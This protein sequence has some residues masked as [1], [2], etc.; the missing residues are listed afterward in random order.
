VREGHSLFSRYLSEQ[1]RP[2]VIHAHNG[3]RAG[4]LARSIAREYGI[5]YVLTEHS[6]QLVTGRLTADEHT[7]VAEAYRDAACRIAVSP[8]LGRALE[9]MF[10][11]DFRPW[12]WIPNFVDRQFAAGAL[13]QRD[14]RAGIT[15]VSVGGLIELKRH[16]ML[17]R[18]FASRFSNDALAKLVIVGDG[19]LRSRI[20]RTAAELG[21]ADR[22]TITGRLSRSGV[23]EQL[24]RADIYVHAS[25][26]ETFGVA[27]IEALACGL[28]VVSTRCGG[29]DDIVTP[30]NG[31]LVPV[32][33]E[34]ALADAMHYL[35]CS[36]DR[37]DRNAIRQAC[38]A[39]YGEQAVAVQLMEIYRTA[40]KRAL[41]P[42]EISK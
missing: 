21:L 8:S 31:M 18:A 30:H 27:V 16:E 24:A 12:E 10:G 29:P 19:P 26:Y 40:A 7:A 9:K 5:P 37:Y 33:D 28:P 41:R 38:L 22:V 15:F 4:I 35:A 25:S 34:A 17:V 1:G 39:T 36:K 20:E 6:S 3:L 13:P 23:R 2:D 42:G 11:A 14:D 32:D